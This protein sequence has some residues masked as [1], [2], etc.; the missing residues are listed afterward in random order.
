MVVSLLKM[1]S[2]LLNLCS[3]H[4]EACFGPNI[5]EISACKKQYL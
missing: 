2:E 1:A 4:R 3:T 5:A